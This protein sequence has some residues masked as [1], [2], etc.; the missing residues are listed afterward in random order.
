MKIK[1]RVA[2]IFVFNHR[3]DKNIPVLEELY[4]S[5]FN[6]IYHLVPFY[7]GDRPNVIPVYESSFCF[8]GYFSQGFKTYF[9][10]EFEHYLFVADDMILN[11][12]INEN[13][14]RTFFQISNEDSFIPEIFEL[15]NFT[16]N[17]TLN[18]DPFVS[19]TERALMRKNEKLSRFL[20][21]RTPDAVEYDPK[22]EYV[23]GMQEI[24]TYSEALEIMKKHG[25]KISPLL[26]TDMHECPRIC[27]KEIK[28]LIRY[29]IRKLQG[30]KYHLN[31]PLVA[32]YSD[33]VIVSSVSIEKFIKYCGVFA[34]TEL[35]VEFAVPTALLLSSEKVVTEP[36]ISK[37][38]IIHWA[39]SGSQ[40]VAFEKEMQKFEYNLQNLLNN[41]PADKLYIHP[42][43]LSKWKIR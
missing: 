34:A 1:G 17:E 29:C 42:V 12:E 6:N 7:D 19:L 41:F 10:E 31:Y 18:V 33:I 40:K 13:N 37:R 11:P 9:N 3:F 5:R 28:D 38:G 15:N 43:K 25:I 16:N 22:K 8:Q 2:L 30:K 14:Y 21:S 24:P 23:E 26:Y 36:E 39:Y 32:S 35:F 27:F 4:K 20:W